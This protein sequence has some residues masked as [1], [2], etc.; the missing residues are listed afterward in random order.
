MQQVDLLQEGLPRG[1]HTVGAGGQLREFPFVQ[2]P[3][4]EF[5]QGQELFLDAGAFG[6][7]VVHAAAVGVVIQ[8]RIVV[9]NHDLA[10]LVILPDHQLDAVL[11]LPVLDQL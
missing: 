11:V 8:R 1:G 6:Y 10:A 5:G 2:L 9:R 3:V 7:G 4:G